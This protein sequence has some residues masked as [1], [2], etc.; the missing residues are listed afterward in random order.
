MTR[1]KAKRLKLKV[2]EGLSL[3]FCDSTNRKPFRQGMKQFR[4]YI[5]KSLT[6]SNPPK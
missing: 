3:M 4:S 1:K 5:Q 6:P 2:R